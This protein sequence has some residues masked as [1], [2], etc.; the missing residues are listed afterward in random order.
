MTMAAGIAAIDD[1]DY[2]MNNCR[3]VAETREFVTAEL[4]KIGFDVIPS[5]TNFVFAKSDAID[6][7][8]LYTQLKANGVLV[9]HFD[10]KKICQYNRIT[11]GSKEQMEQFLQIVK[12]IVTTE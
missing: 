7:G 3:K 4:Q 12:Q 8:E 11:I 9:R 5:Y 10:S 6:G 2:Y 1:N